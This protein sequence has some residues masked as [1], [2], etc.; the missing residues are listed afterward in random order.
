MKVGILTFH[1]AE[2]FGAMLQAVALKE[3][4]ASMGHDVGFIDYWPEKHANIYRIFRTDY[5]QHL[6]LHSKIKAYIV[7][8]LLL[9]V[10]GKRKQKFQSFFRKYIEPY[11]F[12]EITP[13]DIAIYG[14]DQIWGRFPFNNNK[15]D[16]VFFAQNSVHASQHIAYG[17]S[18]GSME[19]SDDEL[20]FIA[21]ALKGFNQISVREKEL[22][23]LLSQIG[24][25]STLVCDPT[26]L[27]TESQWRQLI[28]DERI[29]N[30]PYALFY[31]LQPGSFSKT[32][33]RRIC[34]EKG[35]KLITIAPSVRLSSYLSDE[36]GIINPADF[37]NLIANA[38][39]VFTSSFHGLAFSIIFKRQFYCAY[40]SKGNR[41]KSLLEHIG[42]LDRMIEAGNDKPIPAKSHI[43][44]AD[45]ELRLETY[46]QHSLSF[47]LNL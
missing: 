14:S 2:N 1:R 34:R 45:V 24:F 40:L 3:T 39:L 5:L 43:D 22:Q 35:L 4:L 25:E 44:Y 16:P 29:V 42:L 33:I 28:P 20:L 9:P 23:N 12:S 21:S 47:L 46:R 10:N 18:M 36:L 27:L 41:A 30:E 8:T 32:E 6:R 31:D 7:N 15:F 19:T 37:M 17:A 38:E 13:I 11:L 26:L